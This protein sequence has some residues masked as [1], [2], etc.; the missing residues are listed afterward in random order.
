MLG[1]DKRSFDNEEPSLNGNGNG[2]VNLISAGTVIEGE[3]NCRG[4]LRVDGKVTGRITS[5]SK[6]VIGT[7][8]E[9]EGDIIC[10]HAD[11]FGKYNGNMRIHE[12]LFMKSSCHIKGDVHAGKLVVEAGAVFSGHCHMGEA[13][14]AEVMPRNGKHHEGN[15]EAEKKIGVPA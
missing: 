1:K 5:K 10:Q 4:D 6:V 9:V 12:I 3:I 11:I 15:P 7:T 2:S 14:A 13:P 8:G